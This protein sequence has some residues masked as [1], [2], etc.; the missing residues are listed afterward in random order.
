[1]SKM[2]KSDRF[3]NCCQLPWIRLLINRQLQSYKYV[4]ADKDKG[5]YDLAYKMTYHSIR[6]VCHDTSHIR[7]C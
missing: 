1:M 4:M 7:R 5:D 2:P 3:G 6:P